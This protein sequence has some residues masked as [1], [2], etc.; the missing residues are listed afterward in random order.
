MSNSFTVRFTD[1]PREYDR[2]EEDQP[3]EL[4]LVYEQLWQA[5]QDAQ[6][7]ALASEKRIAELEA[8]LNE[9]LEFFQD[10]AD[11][12]NEH[13]EDGSPRPNKEMRFASTIDE[14]LHGIRF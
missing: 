11:I 5:K 1:D 13:D 12:A 9:C 3:T 8:S 14:A 6:D 7:A 4:D 10:R 2:V